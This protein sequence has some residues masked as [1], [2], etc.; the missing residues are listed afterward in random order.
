MEYIDDIDR[1][2]FLQIALNLDDADLA[3][4]CRSNKRIQSFCQQDNF[5]LWVGRLY[6]YLGKYYKKI[7]LNRSTFDIMNEYRLKFNMSWRNYYITTMDIL[8]KYFIQAVINDEIKGFERE[9]IQAL[10]NIMRTEPFYVFTIERLYDDIEKDEN[11]LKHLDEADNRWIDPNNLIS[12][13]V[14]GTITDENLIDKILNDKRFKY[15]G[16]IDVLFNSR[17]VN[18]KNIEKVIKFLVDNG[19]AIKVFYSEDYRELHEKITI[20][21]WRLY[22]TKNNL[23][24]IEARFQNTLNE[25][26]EDNPEL[27]EEVEK[28]LDMEMEYY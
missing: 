4:F 27:Y 5:S 6:K 8:D 16:Y 12:D 14:N 28:D 24:P 25:I 3:R 9:D 13:I 23:N 2:I 10:L 18:W 22:T 7:D 1:N 11:I 17:L 15:S 19:D 21:L 26:I 20:L